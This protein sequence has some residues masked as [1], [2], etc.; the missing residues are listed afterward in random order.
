MMSLIHSKKF[1]TRQ[2]VDL[3]TAVRTILQVVLDP[4]RHITSVDQG[5]PD[6]RFWTGTP[7]R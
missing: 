5:A 7:V 4:C 1:T 3:S 6:F 2:S